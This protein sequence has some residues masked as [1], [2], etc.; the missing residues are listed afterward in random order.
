MRY[1]PL[2]LILSIL[3][4]CGWPGAKPQNFGPTLAELKPSEL[5]QITAPLPAIS[6]DDVVN[7]YRKVLEISQDQEIQRRVMSRLA[8][9]EMLRSEERQ[10]QAAHVQ[11]FFDEAISLYRALLAENP[12]DE[13]NDRLLYQLAKAQQM[14]GRP[15]DSMAVLDQLV[16]DYPNSIH[17]AEVQFRRGEIL[18]SDGDYRAAQQAYAEV[19]KAGEETPFYNNARYML[20]WSQFKQ[21][22]YR[23][24]L[25]PFTQVLD[26]LLDGD[27]EITVLNRPQQELAKDVLRVM[28]LAFSYLEGADSIASAYERLGV[29]SYEYLFYRHLGELYLEK[30]RFR[31]SA[32]TFQ[33]FVNRYPLS[34]Y[35]PGFSVKTIEVYGE[36]NFPSLVLPA[37]QQFVDNYGIESQYWRD[38]DE[39]VRDT[40]RPHLHRYL[41]ELAQHYHATAQRLQKQRTEQQAGKKDTADKITDAQ[42]ASA[43]LQAGDWYSQFAATFPD[44]EATPGVVYLMAESLFEAGEMPRAIAAYEQVAYRYR[45]P[46]K[47]A[48]AGYAAILAYDRQLQTSSDPEQ[49][50]AWQRQKIASARQF[51][52][53]YRDDNRAVRVLANAAEDL[54]Q[55]QDFSQAI[56]VATLVIAR[57][58]EQELLHTALLVLG[59]SQFALQNFNAAEQAYRGALKT[60]K[61]LGPQGNII[62]R[63]AAS[64]YQQGEQYLVAGESQL[65]VTEYLRIREVAPASEIAISAQYDAASLLL[66]MQNWREAE[67][68]LVDFQARYPQHP[69][70]T[71]IPAK[72]AETWQQ[73]E[74]W[75]KAAGQMAIIAK[76]NSDPEVRRAS[77]FLAAELYEKAADR[78]QAIAFYREYA[79]TYPEPFA[80]AIEAHYKLSELYLVEHEPEKRRFWLRKLVE[81]HRQAGDL[82][83][84]R[85]RYLAAYA[86]TVFAD[87][88]YQRFT[89]ISLTLPLQS[90]LKKKRAAL[91][92]SLSAYRQILAYQVAEFATR[93]NFY[94]GEMYVVLSRDLLA[95][96]RPKL[97]ALELE[98][99][100][101]LLEEQSY[102]FEEKAIE[103]HE[104]NARRSSEGL[105]D[106][107]VQ[108]SFASLAKL[109]PARYAKQEQLE[110]YS[111]EIF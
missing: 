12:Q 13:N 78:L 54:F 106:Q 15:Q 23:A 95:S 42:V 110:A 39:I 4:G 92:K 27:A 8:G 46:G 91:E 18:F 26:Q 111:N 40:L 101:L 82:A 105:Y 14:D 53:I 77:L 74:Q 33:A 107:W 102:P 108:K 98:Q 64:I 44:D 3:S 28:S 104:A 81:G 22:H 75:D 76:S 51:A 79:H 65:A 70:S 67:R 71:G 1:P 109:L 19:L 16:S 49:K 63:I 52:D 30:K 72:L 58:P 9:L 87:D 21:G 38:K 55:H 84:A 83:T 93:A 7:Q 50:N 88:E 2:I 11:R 47:G 41:L 89:S 99:Y 85:S 97:N 5:P 57:Q 86:S 36:G 31:D 43:F 66:E 68:V 62:E 103:I 17:Y 69:L 6:L 35:A 60:L 90:S 34:D 61:E 59:H 20:G 25:T 80:L 94:I 100:E 56:D 73:L 24:A 45:H 10:L 37:K 96:Q 48:D 29:R 32:E